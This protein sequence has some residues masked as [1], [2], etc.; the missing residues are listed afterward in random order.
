MAR[1]FARRFYNSKEWKKCRE[2]F[3]ADR[4]VIDGGL[5]ER[6]AKQ[7]LLVLGEEVHHRKHISPENIS[8]ADITLNHK[9]LEL[10]CQSC[11]SIHHNRMQEE[12]KGL[13][14]DAYGRPVYTPP[15]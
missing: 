9:N 8:N 15:H 5:C 3:I 1:E 2:S 10:L 7:G 4:V 11:H 14:F 13:S 12:R 6:C